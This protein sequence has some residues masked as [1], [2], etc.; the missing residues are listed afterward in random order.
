MNK[1]CRQCEKTFS[2]SDDDIVFFDKISPSYNGVKYLMETP[3]TCPDCRVKTRM[4][5]RNDRSFY[6]RECDGTHQPFVSIYPKETIFPVFHP[7]YWYSDKWDPLGYG[8]VLDVS[9]SFF[10]QWQDLMNKVPR[11]GIDIVN[12]ENSYYCNY[13]GDNKNCYLD[14]AGEDNHDCFYNLFTKHSQ[15]VVDST[16]VYESELVY[17]SINCYKCYK[18][19]FSQYLENCNDCSFCFDLKGCS[20]CLFSSN[21]RQKS[22]CLFNEQ[23]SKEAYEEKI[24][25]LSLAQSSKIN[26]YKEA[27]RK[28][29][30]NAIHRDVY[31]LNSE[32]CSG[33][34]IKNSKNCHFS[35]NIVS[36]E[37]SKYLYDVLD[38][39]DCQDLNYSLYKPECSYNLISTLAMKF[40]S[41][42][43]ASHYC[44]KSFYVDQC[45]N[46]SN[47]FGCIGLNQ[48]AYCILNKQYSKE[49][50]EDLV[51]KIIEKMKMYGEWGEF[52]PSTISPFGYNETVAQEYYPLT[53][54]EVLKHEMKWKEEEVKNSSKIEVDVPDCLSEI[55][56]D[57]LQTVLFC[58]VSGKPYKIIKQELD[59]Y[60]KMDLAVPRRCPDQRHKDRID[61]RNPRTLFKRTC[62]KCG[63]D[64]ETTYSPERPE[65]VY[66]EECYLKKVY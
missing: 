33:N 40:S 17:E 53:K 14:I 60:R 61:Q 2:V 21:L 19:Y 45:N 36:S 20:N 11:L 12:C 15:N 4:S 13:C 64:I 57:I 34:D 10:Q 27:F 26:E 25:G 51:P 66:C 65:K 52:F 24:K 8:Q 3:S 62:S 23:L 46:S 47:L 39:L 35:Y 9:R 50:Y 22:Y 58:E 16:F 37:D 6:L 7:D 42:A 38:A 63:A 43:M 59:F 29:K 30:L 41:C 48:K 28:I 54:D 5:W 44:S 32:R 18:V 49:E 1:T 56:D 55:K 31:S